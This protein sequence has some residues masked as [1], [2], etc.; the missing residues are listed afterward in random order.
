MLTL[1]GFSAMAQAEIRFVTD[2]D[3]EKPF[4]LAHYY[5]SKLLSVDTSSVINGNIV[6]SKSTNYPEGCYVLT[7]WSKT[8]LFNFILGQ[9]QKATLHASLISRH[10]DSIEGAWE[11]SLFQ[12]YEIK[13]QQAL[14]TLLP[15]VTDDP[16]VRAYIEQS[17][18]AFESY[19]D[20][21]VNEDDTL[22]VTTLVK[23]LQ[24][25]KIPDSITQN[26]AKAYVY[27]K[28]HYWDNFSLNDNR[29]LNTPLLEIRLD[30]YLDQIITPL[31]DSLCSAIDRLIARTSSDAIRRF[32]LWH[33]IAKYQQPVFMGQDEVFVY[34][35]DRY[36][37]LFD[38]KHLSEANRNWMQQKAEQL[39]RLAIGNTA[40]DLQLKD[41]NKQNISIQSID[42]EYLILF[43]HDHDC[44]LCDG[45][46]QQLKTIVTDSL[47]RLT[48]LC[49]D[50]NAESRARQADSSS[51]SSF[52]YTNGID[53]Q[54]ENPQQ[55]YDVTSTPLIYLLDR[56]K[57]IIAKQIRAEQIPEITNQYHHDRKPN[58]RRP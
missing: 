54:G 47:H 35:Y 55:A 13:R 4:F 42:S 27:Y 41:S 37:S 20:S 14:Q 48:V 1:A 23:A 36:F 44:T 57:R 16:S 10:I 32:M 7:D 43:F 49:I 52:I 25:P 17:K 45:E 34:L 11:T 18:Q 22:F 24:E 46:L 19:R 3:T 21:I 26:E 58:N 15:Y 38:S 40:P 28:M 2:G 51:V 6:F 33:L 5:G 30:T 12:K 9:D 50:L 29:L 39:R 53:Y 8:P 31:P 56:D